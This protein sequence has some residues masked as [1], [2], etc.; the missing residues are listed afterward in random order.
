LFTNSLELKTVA[1]KRVV[2]LAVS[3]AWQSYSFQ[4]SF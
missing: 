1:S 4:S 3:K 2:I